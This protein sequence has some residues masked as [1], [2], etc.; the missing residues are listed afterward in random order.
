MADTLVRKDMWAFVFFLD[1]A[2]LAGQAN[3][4]HNAR[5]RGSTSLH[6][7]KERRE[8][9]LGAPHISFPCSSCE[10]PNQ[11]SDWTT[12]KNVWRDSVTWLQTGNGFM[13]SNQNINLEP[14]ANQLLGT[15][16]NVEVRLP[17][18]VLRVSSLLDTWCLVFIVMQ[19]L[20]SSWMRWTAMT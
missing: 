6:L 18:G 10:S 13:L 14:I 5:I 16:V 15:K 17:T 2:S 11:C 1:C 3:S 12:R 8:A 7:E 4:N 9:A 20:L 19:W